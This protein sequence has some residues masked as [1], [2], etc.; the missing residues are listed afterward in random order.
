MRGLPFSFASSAA[1]ISEAMAL[2]VVRRTDRPPAGHILLRHEALVEQ[3]E[4]LVL[5]AVV[6][7]GVKQ[8]D[9]TLIVLAVDL[10]Q[11]DELHLERPEH[12]G[13]EEIGRFIERL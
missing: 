3:A 7:D 10:L 11:L 5:D 1:L 4:P 9:K 12:L 8:I 13:A 6:A 2:V